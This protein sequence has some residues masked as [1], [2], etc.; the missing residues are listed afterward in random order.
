[1]THKKA[2]DLSTPR[3]STPTLS[4]AEAI[5]VEHGGKIEA[6]LEI[7][8]GFI[9]LLL[10]GRWPRIPGL[11]WSNC[12][13]ALLEDGEIVPYTKTGLRMGPTFKLTV[14]RKTPLDHARPEPPP[15]A[16]P[17]PDLFSEQE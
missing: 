15:L 11:D 17:A 10:G 8:V 3:L 5:M 9:L 14:Q 16:V 4:V 7:S 6:T 12:G 1:L 2:D 13:Y